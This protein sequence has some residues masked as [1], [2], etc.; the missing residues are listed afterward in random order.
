MAPAGFLQISLCLGCILIVAYYNTMS[1]NYCNVILPPNGG[2]AIVSLPKGMPD[3]AACDRFGCHRLNNG[4][5]FYRMRNVIDVVSEPPVMTRQ[6]RLLQQQVPYERKCETVYFIIDTAYDEAFGHWQ[7]ESAVFLKYFLEIQKDYP[8]I[9][10]HL[11][12]V[13]TFKLLT[14]RQYGITRE[15]VVTSV[16]LPNTCFIAP[17]LGLGD[18]QAHLEWWKPL[19]HSHF[20]H[21]R[22]CDGRAYE[23]IPILV[24]P[25]QTK[26]NYK[27]ND[28]IIPGYDSVI[29]WA[30]QHG[31]SVLH[32]D[33]VDN[34]CDQ[35]K[36][37]QASRIIIVTSG[38]ALYVN[39]NFAANATIIG[40]GNSRQHP[41]YPA[42][43]YVYDEILGWGNTVHFVGQ[44]S[45]PEIVKALLQNG[46][47]AYGA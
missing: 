7:A 9:K 13:Q 17:G 18:K 23:H 8:S 15:Q 20:S 10:L 47:K 45:V 38:S 22:A 29:Q 4:V 30:V 33:A 42:L 40:V 43:Q 46:I 19:V 25:R 11:L 27:N 21:L 34:L 1:N 12:H 5:M 28:R 32:T 26:E 37:V 14:L 3:P 35:I 31:G 41:H 24:M 44:A 16:Q 36:M 6:V 2:S 39:G